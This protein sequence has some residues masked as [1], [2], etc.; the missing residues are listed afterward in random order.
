VRMCWTCYSLKK[1]VPYK[2]KA[3]R[4]T[5]ASRSNSRTQA[6]SDTVP[7]A[8][9]ARVNPL[10]PACAHVVLLGPDG[11]TWFRPKESEPAGHR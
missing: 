8:I 5:R 10:R 6:D 4:R 7:A 1:K 2:L 9:I 11:A 3:T